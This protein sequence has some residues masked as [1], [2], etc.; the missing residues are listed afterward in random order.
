MHH[1]SQF[2]KEEVL[3]D[4]VQWIVWLSKIQKPIQDKR[5]CVKKI[6]SMLALLAAVDNIEALKKEPHLR[7]ATAVAVSQCCVARHGHR[8]ISGSVSGSVSLIVAGSDA[9][10]FHWNVRVL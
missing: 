5:N 1:N 10:T 3:N 8:T 7:R 9:W 2:T 6:D 4:F